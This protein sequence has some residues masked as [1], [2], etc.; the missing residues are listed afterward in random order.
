[1]LD[2][3][4]VCDCVLSIFKECEVLVFLDKCLDG[5]PS[6]L[7]EFELN[8]QPFVTLLLP[9]LPLS[10][11]TFKFNSKRLSFKITFSTILDFKDSR[12]IFSLKRLVEFVEGIRDGVEFEREFWWIGVWKDSLGFRGLDIM[13]GKDFFFE[14]F[15]EKT[16][17]FVQFFFDKKPTRPYHQFQ[18]NI[19][20]LS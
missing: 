7:K 20:P 14:N 19:H 12:N 16:N 17:F 10:S 5:R 1:M 3:L 18:N 6:L 8:L 4:D 11:S 15:I 9:F 13:R 2:P